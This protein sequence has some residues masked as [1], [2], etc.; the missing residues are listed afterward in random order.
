MYREKIV[1]DGPVYWVVGDGGNREGLAP[2]YINPQPVWSAFR[3]AEYGFGLFHV[4]N[5]THAHIEWY[6]NRESGDAMLRDRAWLSTSHF[7][8]NTKHA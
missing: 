4:M 6:E 2:T 8:A 5:Q 1:R 3:Q 7:R